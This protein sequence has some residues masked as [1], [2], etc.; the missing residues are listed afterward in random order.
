MSNRWLGLFLM[1]AAVPT[2]AAAQTPAR[3]EVGP[4]VR[5]DKVSVDGVSRSMPVLGV[6][7]TARLSKTWGLEGEFTRADG[8]EF[9]HSYEGI[10]ETF[11]PEGAPFAELERLGVH[12]RWR[13]AYRPGFGGSV[14]VTARGRVTSRADVLVRLGLA[15]RA[16]TE[17][18][19]YIVLSIPEGIDPSR[20]SSVSFGN[21]ER[22]SNPYTTT[23]Q[24]GGLLMGAELPIRIA[25]RLTV[26]PDVRYVF[27]GG[28]RKNDP[29]R[30]ASIGLRVGW[31]F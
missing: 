26:A 31:A 28:P 18:L 24:R 13:H 19:E 11:A 27:G 9:E 4:V 29:H 15:S 5:T 14:A 20:L 7:A 3:F 2:V 21:G 23:T 30:E 6:A 17:T 22:S 16:Y 10:S 1:V 12:A 8:G 25:A